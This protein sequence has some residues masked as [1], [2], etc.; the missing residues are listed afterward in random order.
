[1]Y[2]V[3]KYV[4][5]D[6]VE[7]E[8]KFAGRY[9]AKGEKR[10]KRKKA[11]PEQVKRQNQWNKEKKVRRLIKANFQPGD[12]WETLKYPKGT[13]KPLSDVVADMSEFLKQVRREY[14]SRGIP[15]KWI[16]RIE[17]GAHGGIHMHIIM[18]RLHGEPETDLVVQR[19]WER[20]AGGHVNH[21][22]LY[23]AGGYKDLAKYLT[24]PPNEEQ[25]AQLSLFDPSEQK[26]MIRYS[27]S[28]NLVRPQPEKKRSHWRTMRRMIMDGIKP[29]QGYYI[30]P[31]SVYYGINPFNGTTYLKYTECRL[32]TLD[33]TAK[34][35]KPE[36]QK[37]PEGGG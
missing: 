19:I 2:E 17:I 32:G 18:N 4:F 13:R 35:I 5:H 20:I 34:P 27:S 21:S 31:E 22:N 16:N 1:M 26:K 37:W 7:Y 23:A 30:D 9:G 12:L 24:K 8:Y 33:G 25:E 3:S 10:A 36:W 14:R 6:S 11:T 28:R 15:F 29:R